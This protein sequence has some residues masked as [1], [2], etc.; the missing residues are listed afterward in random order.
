MKAYW[1]LVRAQLLLFFRNKN[2]LI[3]TFFLPVFMMLALGLLLSDGSHQISLKAGVVDLD[4]TAMSEKWK[5]DFS[6]LESV[7]LVSES[8]TALMKKLESGDLDFV[9]KI[10]KGFEKAYQTKQS[11]KKVRLYMD[12]GNKTTSDLASTLV[13]QAVDRMN[14]ETVHF[15]PV[16]ETEVVPIHSRALSYIDFLVPGI[17]SLMIMSNNLN[18]VAATIASWRERGIL[19]RMQGTP[20]KSSTFIAGQM[21]ARILLNAIQAV[22]VLLVAYFLFGVHVYG[23]WGSLILL[24]LLGTFT[25]MSMGFIVASL[26]KTPESASPIAG[27]IAFPM[28]FVGGIFFPV[29]DLP[30]V[31]QSIVQ[32]IPIV[33]LTDALRGV[34]ND[35]LALSQLIMPVSILLAWAVGAFVIAAWTFKWDVK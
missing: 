3:W 6:R 29:R 26:S 15:Q 20:L 28:I 35:G 30:G 34:M 13:H 31:L 22:A 33:H 32:V 25:F 23:G 1:Q 12:P 2:T 10:E 7:K 8:E 14:K 9:V 5:Q 18:G 19:R 16:I 21:T 11:A 24:I 4:Q 17:L 27:L